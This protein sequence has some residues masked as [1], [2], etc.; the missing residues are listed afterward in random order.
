M[1]RSPK[2]P[3]KN[4]LPLVAVFIVTPCFILF[5]AARIDR[6][7]IYDKSDNHLLFVTF[8][9]DAAGKN[10]GRS[11]FAG[12]STFLRHTTFQTDVQGVVT[13]ETSVDFDSNTVFSTTRNVSAGKTTFSVFDQ[14]G[15]DQLGGA[16]SYSVSGQNAYDVTQNGAV[17]NRISYDTAGDGSLSRINVLDKTGSLLY[18]A[19]V[20]N[21]TGVLQGNFSHVPGCP[22]IY[23]VKGTRCA[24]TFQVSK[25]SLV[26]LEMFTVSGR[27][28]GKLF[29]GQYTA[30]TYS[31]HV[32]LNA[33]GTA[34][35]AAGIYLFRLSIDGASAAVRTGMVERQQGAI[36]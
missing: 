3:W 13:K 18:Y 30:G 29:C 11:V 21:A 16:A 27:N 31:F 35:P 22:G 14:F 25:R 5:G 15:L 12:D 23:L 28:A 19:A 20:T 2:T 10:T 8:D 32:Q 9:Y 26:S 6:I 24:V 1:N 17:I 33:G 4:I 7:D 36:Q 34:R